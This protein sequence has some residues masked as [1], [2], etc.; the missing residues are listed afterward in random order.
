M[1]RQAIVNFAVALEIP[2]VLEGNYHVAVKLDGK[3]V[4]KSLKAIKEKNEYVDV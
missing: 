2:E 4:G 1:H 3:I